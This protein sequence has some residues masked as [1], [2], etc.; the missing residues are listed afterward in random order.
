MPHSSHKR[1]R[2]E[3]RSRWAA[4][5]RLPDWARELVAGLRENAEG[6]PQ[7]LRDAAE[8]LRTVATFL[9]REAINIENGA[10]A[11]AAEP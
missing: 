3:R 2:E 4:L 8:A 1:P 10:L 9:D 11:A 5:I 6:V 7:A